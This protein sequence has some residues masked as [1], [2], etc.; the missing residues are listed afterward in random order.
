MGNIVFSEQAWQEYLSWQT[1]DKK[2]LRKINQLL[3]DISRNGYTGM[4]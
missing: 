1:E 4:G 3:Q 2:T